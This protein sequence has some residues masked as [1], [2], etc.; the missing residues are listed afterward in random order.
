[1]IETIKFKPEFEKEL[2]RLGVKTRFLRN[3][4]NHCNETGEDILEINKHNSFNMFMNVSFNFHKTPEGFDFWREV[5]IGIK[6]I[7]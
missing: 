3:R 2:L 1:M 5:A 7:K 4:I 6:P